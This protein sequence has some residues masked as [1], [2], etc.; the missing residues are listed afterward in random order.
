[1]ADTDHKHREGCGSMLA[2]NT[3]IPDTITP[4]TELVV[5]QRLAELLRIIR[6][7]DTRFQIVYDYRPN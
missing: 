6:L 5:P 1:M 3:V 4:Q 7:R 2:N